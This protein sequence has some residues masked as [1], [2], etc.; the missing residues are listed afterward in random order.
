MT[1]PT[2]TEDEFQRRRAL[3][4]L[5]GK[6][7]EVWLD[8]TEAACAL[9]TT[10]ERALQVREWRCGS[11]GGCMPG[12]G[13]LA[14]IIALEGGGGTWRWVAGEA[15]RAWDPLGE[16]SNQLLGMAICEV[17]ATLLGEAPDEA[18]WN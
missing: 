12:D 3:L 8:F 9:L 17:A 15:T 13:G 11:N 16:D 1:T 2:T 18:P 14:R 5:S 6:D 4:V 10:L 7:G